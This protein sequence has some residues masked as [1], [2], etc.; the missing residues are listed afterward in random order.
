MRI[1]E[2]MSRA[3][4]TIEA[5]ESAHAAIVRMLARKIR[6]LPVVDAQGTLVGIVTD[7]NLRHFCSR[8]TSSRRSGVFPPMRS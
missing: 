4:A 5:S 8:P 7:R 6:H 1:S 2:V 3:V